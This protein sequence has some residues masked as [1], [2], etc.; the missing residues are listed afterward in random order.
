LAMNDNGIRPDLNAFVYF[1]G[2]E[3]MSEKRKLCLPAPVCRSTAA[4]DFNGDHR[5][6]LAFMLAGELRVFFQSDL[7]FE[8]KRYTTLAIPG[9]QITADDVDEDGFADLIVRQLSGEV[10]IYWGGTKGLDP[11][12]ALVVKP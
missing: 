4:G 6:D 3:G 1:G 10:A 5:Q 2:P 12:L 11:T 7:G 9:N 8:P